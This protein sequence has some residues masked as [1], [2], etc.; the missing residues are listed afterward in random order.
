MENKT[1]NV[2]GKVY[3]IPEIDFNAVC[4]LEEL[5]LDFSKMN[6]KT[7]SVGRILLAFVMNVSLEEAGKAYSKHSENNNNALN[8]IMIPLFNA[9]NES[10]FFQKTLKEGVK[11]S[12]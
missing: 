3:K 8:E 1:I 7:F 5:G 6:K 4:E 10:D 11:K 9:V 2:N 12:K